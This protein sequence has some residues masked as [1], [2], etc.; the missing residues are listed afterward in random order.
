M[1]I[2]RGEDWGEAAPIPPLAV[3]VPTDAGLAALVAASD[4]RPLRLV[5]GD[6]LATLGGSSSGRVVRRVP[7]DV[8]SV[9]ADDQPLTAVAHVVARGRTWWRGLIVAVM[10]AEHI[11]PWDVAPRAHPNDG[12]LDVLEVD[13]A[14]SLRARWQARRRLPNGTHI[15]HPAIAMSRAKQRS[16]TFERPLRL[17]V[18]GVEHGT[19]RSLGVAIEPDGVIVYT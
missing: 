3:A 15:P 4:S 16:W 1:T 14:M 19:V 12:Q 9:I 5:G 11:G 2:R 10:N 18:D 8:M 6:L 7:I 13:A 17:W